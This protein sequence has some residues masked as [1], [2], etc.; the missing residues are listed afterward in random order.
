MNKP[1]IKMSQNSYRWTLKRTCCVGCLSQWI[2]YSRYIHCIKAWALLKTEVNNAIVVAYLA[3]TIEFFP[4]NPSPPLLG[5]FITFI[6]LPGAYMLRIFLGSKIEITFLTDLTPFSQAM[7]ITYM[8]SN[9]YA[10]SSPGESSTPTSP[11]AYL[12][13]NPVR[14]TRTS[15]S[16]C[17]KSILLFSSPPP[18]PKTLFHNPYFIKKQF[19]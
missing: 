19:I 10:N 2:H 17:F 11:V 6:S 16:T 12:N 9:L 15:H 7:P 18:S 8:I 3:P 1:R 4:V 5:L 14:L 13:H